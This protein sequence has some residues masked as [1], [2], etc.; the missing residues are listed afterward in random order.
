MKHLL[1]PAM[2]RGM[3]AAL[4]MTLF[5]I[6]AGASLTGCDNG[7]SYEARLEDARIA[8]DD[9]DYALAK[10]ILLELPQ[11]PEVLEYLSNAIAGDDLNLDL[12]NILSTMADL[13]DN[14][15][16][17]SIDMVGLILGDDGEP[18][19][20]SDISAKLSAA[21]DA[22]ELYEAIAGDH[23]VESLTDNQKIQLGLLSVTRTVLTLAD[24]LYDELGESVE[25]TEDWISSN[26]D[27]DT[28]SVSPDQTELDSINRDMEYIGLAVDALADGSNDMEDD[29]TDFKSELTGGDNDASAED[30][31]NYFDAM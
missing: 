17:G 9:S 5:V 22:I 23:G 4:M 21:N 8:L 24:M 16:S 28:N 31:N 20:Q 15:N 19:S 29:F 1:F 2:P 25:M 7:D 3:I 14:G 6:T 18:L 27:P 26:W 10:S 12:L 30:I 11:T 13:E